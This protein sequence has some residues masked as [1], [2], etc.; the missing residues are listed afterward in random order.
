MCRLP[1]SRLQK[2]HTPSWE[3]GGLEMMEMDFVRI[4]MEKVGEDQS[5]LTQVVVG[6]DTDPQDSLPTE[7]ILQQVYI[8]GK[9]LHSQICSG[10][11]DQPLG[12]L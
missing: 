8:I 11:L 12:P 6:C 7:D 9:M 5:H 10:T 3:A 4:A 2:P 1:L